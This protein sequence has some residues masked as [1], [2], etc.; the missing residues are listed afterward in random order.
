MGGHDKIGSDGMT[1]QKE[2]RGFEWVLCAHNSFSLLDCKLWGLG[3]GGRG[4]LCGSQGGCLLTSNNRKDSG[5]IS[6]VNSYF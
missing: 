5:G 1:T 2:T 3:W 4:E 6:K